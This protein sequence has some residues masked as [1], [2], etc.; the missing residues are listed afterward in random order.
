MHSYIKTL[1]FDAIKFVDA[2]DEK[3]LR[4]F[5]NDVICCYICGKYYFLSGYDIVH[6]SF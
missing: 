5:R 2:R 1:S 4:W 3:G 6:Q